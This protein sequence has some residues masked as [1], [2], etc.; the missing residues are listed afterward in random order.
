MKIKWKGKLNETNTFPENEIPI[1][2]VEFL[3]GQ[4]KLEIFLMIVPIIIFIYGCVYIKSKFIGE[5]E[6]NLLGYITGLLLC[7]PFLA[8]HEFLHAACF[9]QKSKIEIFYTN[10]GICIIPSTPLAKTR[11]I[12]TL[13]LPAVTLGI[14]PLLIWTFIPYYYIT[15]NSILFIL[16]AGCLGST[17]GDLCNLVHVIKEMPK[18]SVVMVSGLKCYYY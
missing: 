16:S 11:Y 8:V 18:G 6:L 10:W 5:Y 9:P 3:G 13:L 15:F 1:N 2:A 17:V 7:I 4:S 12:C 14:I